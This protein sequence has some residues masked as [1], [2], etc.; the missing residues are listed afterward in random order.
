[1]SERAGFDHATLES[2]ADWYARLQAAPAD[3]EL[4]GQWRQWLEQ[5][6]GQR[7]AWSY[8]ERISQRF[9]SLQ[10]QGGAAHQA[11]ASMRQGKH[12]RRRLLSQMGV[13]AGIGVLGWAGWR[14]DALD[15]VR[16]L[17]AGYRTALGERRSEVL[18]DGTRLWLN[19]GTAVD[20][21]F[22]AAHRELRLYAGEVLI[23]TARGDARPLR[24]RT[25]AGLLE[26]LG[27]RFS[28]RDEGPRT[29]LNVYQGAVRTTC[30]DS[31]G[32]ATVQAGQGVTFDARAHGPLV[33]AEARREAWSRGLLLAEDMPLGR[34]IE[35]LGSYRRGHIGLDPALSELRVMGS[36]PLNDTDLVLAQLQ[37]ALPIKVQ[38]RF[39]WWV[40]LVP[41]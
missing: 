3:A 22:D 14:G 4:L 13:M 11:L 27:T 8:I 17:N 6:E 36:F 40:T 9:A 19:S 1:M 23:E 2:A 39:D 21:Q 24:V 32:S 30:A 16:A 12:S 20:V 7:L 34:F 5:G 35:E 18:A 28:V 33:R 31:G 29:E 25:R 38:R 26:P 10:Q 41:R 15:R 37:D